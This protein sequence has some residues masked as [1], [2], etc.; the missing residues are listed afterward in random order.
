[1]KFALTTGRPRGVRQR[2]FSQADV[3]VVQREPAFDV[4]VDLVGDVADNT[5]A[6]VDVMTSPANWHEKWFGT[7]AVG[8]GGLLLDENIGFPAHSILV[9]NTTSQWVLVEPGQRAIPPYTVGWCLPA[10]VGSQVARVRLLTP[11]GLAGFTAAAGER[12]WVGFSEAYLP[13]QPGVAIPPALITGG[14]N[15][16]ANAGLPSGATPVE[17]GSGN[18]ANAIATASLPA[19]VGKTTYITGFEVT[20]DGSTAVL[21][22]RVTVGVLVGGITEGY[23]YTFVA[24]VTTQDLTLAVEYGRGIPANVPNTA[25]NVS[26]PAGGA[27][28][29]NAEVNAHGY[30]L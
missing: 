24:G 18:V 16:G 6:Y 14:V 23:T 1:M 2:P 9:D 8:P 13:P 25:I 10:P 7:T 27:G 29:T 15:P 19:A 22:V 17:A 28:N 20:S 11:P 5:A 12:G 26:L 30:Q 21:V 4:P 3:H